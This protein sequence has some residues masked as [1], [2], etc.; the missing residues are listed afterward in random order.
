MTTQTI[1]GWLGIAL[2][3]CA[4]LLAWYES[5]RRRAAEARFAQSRASALELLAELEQAATERDLWRTFATARDA[6]AD[7]SRNAF[8]V[9][10]SMLRDA[11]AERDALRDWR[12]AQ[13]ADFPFCHLPPRTARRSAAP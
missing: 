8:V 6:E 13:F 12:A 2:A 10:M 7:R 11:T 3:L 4:G 1:F 9:C 5:R